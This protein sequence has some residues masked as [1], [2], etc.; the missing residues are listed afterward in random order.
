MPRL[1][2][3]VSEVK[4]VSQVRDC[5]PLTRGITVSITL[6]SNLSELLSNVRRSKTNGACRLAK[7]EFFFSWSEIQN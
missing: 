7:A 5:W 2:R 4:S 1:Q 3:L 6:Y